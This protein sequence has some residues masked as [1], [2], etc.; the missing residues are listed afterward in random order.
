MKARKID[1]DVGNSEVN[2][3]NSGLMKKVYSGVNYAGKY[4]PLQKDSVCRRNIL[5]F[6]YNHPETH[7]LQNIFSMYVVL[8]AQWII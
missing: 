4:F 1:I 7:T 8:S 6:I 2:I 3:I 5:Q